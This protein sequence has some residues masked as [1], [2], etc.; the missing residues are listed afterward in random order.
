MSL[1]KFHL[2]S[3]EEK[4]GQGMIQCIFLKLVSPLL[5]LCNKV[6]ISAMLLK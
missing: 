6:M 1:V 3:S 5:Q 2:A 4:Q